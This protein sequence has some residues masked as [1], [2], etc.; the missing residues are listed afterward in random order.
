MKLRI[1]VI[2]ILSGLLSAQTALAGD[3]ELETYYEF[4][5]RSAS[6]QVVEEDLKDYFDYYK[7]NVKLAGDLDRASSYRVK[8]QYY[9]KHYNN[10]EN[11]NNIYNWYG[12]GYGQLIYSTD[13]FSIKIGPDFD[14]KA[15]NYSNSANN[16]YRQIRFDFPIT[17]KR[18]DDWTIKLGSGINSYQYPNAPKSQFKSNVRIDVSK[19]FFDSTCELR[20]FYKY[21]YI[22]RQKLLS[23][24]EKTYGVSADT[25]IDNKILRNLE[26]GVEQGMDGTIEIEDRE[27]S[28]DYKYFEWFIKGKY[29]V[30]ELI[31]G[32]AKYAK[33]T[34][35]YANFSDNYNGF[36][37]D[38]SWSIKAFER[39]SLSLDLKAGYLHKQFRFP[40]ASSPF[41]YYNNTLTQDA[42]LEKKKDWKFILG[43][44]QK[45]Y[46]FP[47]VRYNDKIYYTVKANFEKSIKADFSVGFDYRYTYK[48]FLHKT[49][50][51]ENAYRLH[52]VWKF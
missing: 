22:S 45:F 29:V 13:V 39:G 41:S 4:G 35:V 9:Q 34:R 36:L 6:G 11:L 1:G 8:Y 49:A 26:A 33:L 32:S 14:Y 44:D 3:S 47:S 46:L 43:A 19:K 23:R 12:L 31:R 28:Y 20:A 17:F 16:S 50:I 27:D 7:G 21:Q 24:Q 10:L 38:N 5:R 52:C 48:N 40:Y 51:I 15:K 30:A 25:K 18:K 37:V 42:E 2:I